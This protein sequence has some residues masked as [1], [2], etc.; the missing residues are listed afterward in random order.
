MKLIACIYQV[1]TLETD[2][3]KIKMKAVQY[4]SPTPQTA[5]F[6]L[7]LKGARLVTPA[8]AGVGNRDV[9]LTR[10]IYRIRAITGRAHYHERFVHEFD[11]PTVWRRDGTVFR[12]DGGALFITEDLGFL[13]NVPA[14]NGRKGLQW[15]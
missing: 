8:S 11:A 4:I 14:L 3:A 5:L 13:L 6:S 15:R 2:T 7:M 9:P 1:E 10:I 12:K